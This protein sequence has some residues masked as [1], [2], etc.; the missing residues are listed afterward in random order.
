MPRRPRNAIPGIPLHITARGNDRVRTFHTDQDRARYRTLLI[1][2]SREQDCA[3][4]AWVLMPNHVHLLV[5]PGEAKSASRMMQR[6]GSRFVRYINAVYGRTGTLWEGRFRSF[7]VPN[8]RY[9]LTCARYI[10][11]NPVR[12]GLVSAPRNYTWSSYRYHALGD[13]DPVVAP[14][15]V[16]ERLGRTPRER[17]AEWIALC[18]DE[19]LPQQF[20]EVRKATRAP[21]SLLGVRSATEFARHG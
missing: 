9:L 13:P 10:E 15:A 21:H 19:S 8:D 20:E 14:H 18:N 4:H 6:V 11:L 16:Y 1:E 17:Q 3:I 2:T 5:T 7:V 12:A